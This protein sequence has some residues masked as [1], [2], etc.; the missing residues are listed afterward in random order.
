MPAKSNAQRK[1]M[2]IAL[3]IKRGTAPASYSSEAA[4]LAE[5]MSE[6]DLEDFASKSVVKDEDEE[7]EEIE[8]CKMKK[9][10]PGSG[11]TPGPTYGKDAVTGKSIRTVKVGSH[12]SHFAKPSKPKPFKISY[13]LAGGRNYGDKSS[14]GKSSDTD[15]S[16]EF[17][18]KKIK[19]LEGD[20]KLK[21]EHQTNPPFEGA[22]FDE[23]KH[24]WVS[25]EEYEENK[26]VEAYGVM[27]MQ[28]KPW[29]KVFKNTA[30]LNKWT[31]KHD[32]EVH[33][34]SK[35]GIVKQEDINKSILDTP[36]QQAFNEYMESFGGQES[37][38]SCDSF[39]NTSSPIVKITSTY[40]KTTD[41]VFP[42]YPGISNKNLQLGATKEGRE[43]QPYSYEKTVYKNPE[44]EKLDAF[45]DYVYKEMPTPPRPGLVFNRQSHRWERPS[46]AEPA[47]E[48]S[49]AEKGKWEYV[50]VD[51][52]SVYKPYAYEYTKNG[53]V[54]A[55]ISR[56]E[57]GENN[58]LYQVSYSAD[59]KSNFFNYKHPII[60]AKEYF[61]TA[62]E[63][64]RFAES[65]LNSI[66]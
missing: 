15:F 3:G 66:K 23:Q 16:I 8:N 11:R 34:I 56:E 19:E 45:N 48:Q 63:A 62:K 49:R 37:K 32:A 61:K 10:G 29:R 20:C 27:G 14:L 6:K 18:E 64:Q 42:D 5:T 51:G 2:A 1:L 28:S 47:K 24:R 9:G 26:P 59:G 40:D 4:K 22:R 50:D 46:N 54:V 7:T 53:K 58:G 12:E 36:I 31:E 39:V 30:E 52:S 35:D 43:N 38:D 57:E 44:S 13:G 65:K 55:A 60:T 17:L 41:E 33:A 21:K 25:D